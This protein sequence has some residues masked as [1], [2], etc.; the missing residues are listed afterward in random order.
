[1]VAG[2]PFQELLLGQAVGTFSIFSHLR[3]TIVEISLEN[4][5]LE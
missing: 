2:R 1:V 5:G 4:H 3:I